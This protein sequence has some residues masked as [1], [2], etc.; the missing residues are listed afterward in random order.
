MLFM[1]NGI[2]CF[3]IAISLAS[4]SLIWWSSHQVASP[5]RRALMDYHLEYLAN[6]ESHGI[7]IEKFTASDGTPCLVCVPEGNPGRRG[8]IIRT[9][10]GERDVPLPPFGGIQGTLVLVH[11]R[12]G[13][14]EDYLPIAERLCAAGFRCIIPDL[15]AHGDHPHDIATYG[16]REAALPARVLD[17]AS[18]LFKFDPEPAGLIGMS[19]GGSVA[20]HAMSEPEAPWK[21]LVIIS[22]FDSFPTVI[23]NQATRY[24][25]VLGPLCGMR[26]AASTDGKPM[27]T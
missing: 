16:V 5:T 21:A 14:K 1:E 12:K 8:T 27:S 2:T 3:L 23:K 15:P 11:G 19:M 10:L 26:S 22:S 17:E 7:R 20:M 4:F 25:G 18:M 24:S 9:Q 6:P 13:R